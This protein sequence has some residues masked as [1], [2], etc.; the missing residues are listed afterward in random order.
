MVQGRDGAL[1]GTTVSGGGGICGGLFGCGTV[2]R[3]AT[4]GEYSIL[5]RFALNGRSDGD[6]PAPYLIQATDGYFYGTTNSGGDAA[7][8]R[9]GTVF[10]LSPNGEK[11]TL[12]SFGPLNQ[13]P[14]APVGG[15]I[16]AKDG[17]FYGILAENGYLGAV[18]ARGGYGAA[19]KMTV[20]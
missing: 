2:F 15:V 3:L 1:Y 17:S 9:T 18:E 19:F 10:R 7:A 20:N 16:Q 8:D 5:Y 13:K 14:S 12:Y 11:T 6:G 4:N